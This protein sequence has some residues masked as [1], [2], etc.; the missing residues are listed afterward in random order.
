[1]ELE[2]GL[3]TPAAILPVTPRD[4][5]VELEQKTRAWRRSTG[6]DTGDVRHHAFSIY[7][8]GQRHDDID[9]KV[10]TVFFG[11]STEPLITD[12][13]ADVQVDLVLRS[14]L[15][16]LE[17]QPT[18]EPPEARDRREKIHAALLQLQGLGEDVSA[19]L[20]AYRFPQ[21]KPSGLSPLEIRHLLQQQRGVFDF[22]LSPAEQ[23]Q[24]SNKLSD[25]YLVAE[26]L[27]ALALQS[28]N[29]PDDMVIYQATDPTQVLEW[30]S[31]TGGHRRQVVS[32]DSVS[33]GDEYIIP[34][35]S[36]AYF[37]PD[38]AHETLG[39]GRRC[40]LYQIYVPKGFPIYFIGFYQDMLLPYRDARFRPIRYL[41]TRKQHGSFRDL[42][43]QEEC[44]E[45][46]RTQA[47]YTD[48]MR[49]LGGFTVSM[50]T[51]KALWPE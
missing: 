17:K 6:F 8:A 39:E 1:M 45:A 5:Q 28:P 25:D 44:L 9:E 47:E 35:L 12:K 40:C 16:R 42:V 3:E 20:K 29:A 7:Y 14:A 23:Q 48:C 22:R 38:F 4:V 27:N 24:L 34:H 37:D 49:E 2:L 46:A 30:V 13:P 21:S 19:A 36:L 32:Y 26:M 10:R 41:V 11:K 33:V 31:T 15:G 18:P 43:A 51:L 50:V